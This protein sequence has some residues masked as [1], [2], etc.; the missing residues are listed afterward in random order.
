MADRDQKIGTTENTHTA[1]NRP[2]VVL[3]SA[4]GAV[5]LIIGGFLF[6][7]LYE[8][9]TT[10]MR[11]IPVVYRVNKFTG[12]TSFC[13]LNQC[14]DLREAPSAATL[15]PPAKAKDY[16]TANLTGSSSSGSEMVAAIGHRTFGAWI[17]GI[18]LGIVL[19]IT[20]RSGRPIFP[21]IARDLAETSRHFLKFLKTS[22]D[23]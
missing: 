8:T 20:L 17:A 9:R 18:V 1:D 5:G 6:G 21:Q 10:Q 3:A 7:G 19:T 13:I 16:E 11:G 22:K 14:R 15:A 12:S 23:A 2:K 4:I